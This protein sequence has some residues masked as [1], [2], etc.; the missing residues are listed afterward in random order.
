VDS[1]RVLFEPLARARHAGLLDRGRTSN[2]LPL[3][4]LFDIDSELLEPVVRI[5]DRRVH[6]H[7]TAADASKGGAV[8]PDDCGACAHELFDP[9]EHARVRDVA[10]GS[11]I[12]PSDLIEGARCSEHPDH[13][14]IRRVDVREE[15]K[16]PRKLTRG[17]HREMRKRPYGDVDHGERGAG[18][19]NAARLRDR[20]LIRP[21]ELVCS[22]DRM[23]SDVECTGDLSLDVGCEGSDITMDGFATVRNRQQTHG[24][25]FLLR[26]PIALGAFRTTHG[27][28]SRGEA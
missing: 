24:C 5:R 28:A 27:C 11:T 25:Q 23:P 10:P 6:A 9:L 18:I 22:Y 8:K 26:P 3:I 4:D 17:A 7:G 13:A 20:E 21:D 15:K 19:G 12:D 16:R 14:G 2:E 1:C